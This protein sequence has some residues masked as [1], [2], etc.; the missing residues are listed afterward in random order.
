MSEAIWA[1][2]WI[3]MNLDLNLD[4]TKD[5]NLTKD[6]VQNVVLVLAKDEVK[7]ISS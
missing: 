1:N 2:I 3:I 5:L 4:L 7:L 6:Y